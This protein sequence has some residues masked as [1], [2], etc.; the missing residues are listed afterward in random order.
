MPLANTMS[1]L[2]DAAEL[3]RMLAVSKPTIW[4]MK[5]ANK[6]PKEIALSAQC[7]R[8]RLR[9][10]DPTTGVLDWIDIGCPPLN[11]QQIPAAETGER[12]NFRGTTHAKN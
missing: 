9:T 3:A 4:R 1:V 12:G 7:V 11:E 8:W 5:E 6:L 10:G 2:I